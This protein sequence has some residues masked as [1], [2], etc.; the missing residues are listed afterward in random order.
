[1]TNADYIRSLSDSLL[2]A[3]LSG[4]MGFSEEKQIDILERWLAEEYDCKK[5]GNAVK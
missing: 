4:L 3:T 1:M 5:W 2:H